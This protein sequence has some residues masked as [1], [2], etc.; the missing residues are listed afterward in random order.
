M[1]KGELQANNDKLS[2]S[3]LRSEAERSET[4]SAGAFG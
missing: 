4:E 1:S 3:V 2:G